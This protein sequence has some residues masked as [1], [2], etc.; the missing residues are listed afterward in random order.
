MFKNPKFS[1]GGGN[2][3]HIFARIFDENKM[4]NDFRGNTNTRYHKILTL[5]VRATTN[6]ISLSY[7]EKWMLSYTA[8]TGK[9]VHPQK[10][11]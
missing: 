4:R 8:S 10:S 9:P 7:Y 3:Q 1:G 5:R 11:C 2:T 6:K